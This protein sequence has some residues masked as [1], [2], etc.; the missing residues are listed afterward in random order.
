MDRV[1]WGNIAEWTAA[2]AVAIALWSAWWARRAA[3]KADVAQSR[4]TRALEAAA[5]AQVRLAALGLADS[6]MRQVGR[7]V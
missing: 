2:A 3:G 1:Q 4:A 7:M 5:V 6:P